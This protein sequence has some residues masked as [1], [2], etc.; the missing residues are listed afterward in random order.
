MAFKR[1]INR[2]YALYG[3]E[4]S[5]GMIDSWV[6]DQEKLDEAK[7]PS[8][9]S[10]K[11]SS[12]KRRLQAWTSEEL[13]YLKSHYKTE[14]YEEMGKKLGRSDGS[15][16]GKLSLLGW[17]KSG[18]KENE[19]NPAEYV[20]H[21]SEVPWTSDEDNY[22]KENFNKVDHESIAVHLGRALDDMYIRAYTLGLN[23]D[24]LIKYRDFMKWEVV[25]GEKT[26]IQLQFDFTKVPEPVEAE[27]VEE[28]KKTEEMKE[29]LPEEKKTINLFTELKLPLWVWLVLTGI[30]ISTVL[31]FLSFI[32]VVLK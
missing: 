8:K 26:P 24:E 18:K 13:E 3:I 21:T 20:V 10:P 31:S 23:K 15:V 25:E 7:K 12:K 6:R 9:R 22:L 32:I 5:L 16:G 4:N 29:E 1:D 2:D 27:K 17:L 14:T 19:L 11:R 28:K 30:L